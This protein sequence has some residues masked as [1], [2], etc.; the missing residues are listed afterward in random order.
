MGRS[1]KVHKR[2]SR[3]ERDFKK[4]AKNSAPEPSAAVRDDAQPGDSEPELDLPGPRSANQKKKDKL[5]SALKKG[6]P[7]DKLHKVKGGKIAK[8]PPGKSRLPKGLD[9]DSDMED[10]DEDDEAPWYLDESAGNSAKPPKDEKKKA[11]SFG[12]DPDK[13][14][15]E[16]A[17]AKPKG[18]I[19]A[20]RKDYVDMF[21]KG[22]RKKAA[23]KVV[24][25]FPSRIS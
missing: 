17:E 11:V 23:K 7:D 22:P 20:G 9:G 10:A 25:F 14:K 16:N 18:Y 3:Q 15:P 21:Q 12:A 19:L 2:F 6:T 8:P 1:A 4:I 5:K 13:P 24:N